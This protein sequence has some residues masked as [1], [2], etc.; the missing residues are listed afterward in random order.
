MIMIKIDVERMAKIL[1]VMTPEDYYERIVTESSIYAAAR[2]RAIEEDDTISDEEADE[3]AMLAE[4]EDRDRIA[5]QYES[6]IVSVFE[7]EAANLKLD[8][9]PLKTRRGFY[10]I[11]PKESWT[12]SA[13]KVRSIVHGV[14]GFWFTSFKE[15]LASGPYT[16]RKA[17]EKH[18][19]Y[20]GDQWKLYG[21]ASP[22]RRVSTN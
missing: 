12:E 9:T 15:F 6:A 4:T 16:P 11:T 5:R 21:Y 19:G 20:L 18:L 2:E 7:Q 17:V 14:S 3:K 1:G 10:A 13:V 22:E 8:V